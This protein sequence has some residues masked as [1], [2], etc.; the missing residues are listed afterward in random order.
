MTKR[1]KTSESTEFGSG[2]ENEYQNVRFDQN[3]SNILSET[4]IQEPVES[5]SD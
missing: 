4:K 3:M 1:S 2:K 5:K